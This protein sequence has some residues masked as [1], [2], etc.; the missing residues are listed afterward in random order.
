[1]AN[2]ATIT[3]MSWHNVPKDAA[4]R[5]P[6]QRGSASN[7]NQRDLI[8]NAKLIAVLANPINVAAPTNLQDL[9]VAAWALGLQLH[10]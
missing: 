7:A 2:G 5:L 1:V 8:P 6:C 10:G 4:W 9:Q 3:R